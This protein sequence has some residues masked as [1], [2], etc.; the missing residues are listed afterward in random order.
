MRPGFGYTMMD[1]LEEK[2][3]HVRA[4]VYLGPSGMVLLM[5]AAF[6]SS[7]TWVCKEDCMHT[8]EQ[9][10]DRL[11]QCMDQCEVNG[12]SKKE[13]SC[14]SMCHTQ[15]GFTRRQVR[16][17]QS[18]CEKAC[19][20]HPSFMRFSALLGTLALLGVAPLLSTYKGACR[21]ECCVGQGCNSRLALF[22]VSWVA[23]GLSCLWV[24]PAILEDPAEVGGKVLFGLTQGIAM[25]AMATSRRLAE[26]A[27]AQQARSVVG[28]AS[29]VAGGGTSM[30]VIGAG[31]NGPSNQELHVQIQQLQQQVSDLVKLQTLQAQAQQHAPVAAAPAPAAPVVAVSSAPANLL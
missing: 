27:E 2:P 28:E 19:S 26:A 8:G 9:S 18:E 11:L 6:I 3:P 21:C 13:K 16:K 30:S 10:E 20:Q 12:G 15:M 1:G 7:S 23:Y 4:A 24:L 17:V 25:S 5:L 14:E 29:W 31:S 22:N